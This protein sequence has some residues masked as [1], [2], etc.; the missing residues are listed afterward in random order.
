MTSRAA[1]AVRILVVEAGVSVSGPDETGSPDAPAA[2]NP[3]R[4]PR[5]SSFSADL[6]ALAAASASIRDPAAAGARGSCGAGISPMGAGGSMYSAGHSPPQMSA[7]N[8]P[9]R[10]A[11]AVPPQMKT[12]TTTS[13]PA[14]IA[15]P[16]IF[17]RRFT[18]VTIDED[19]SR[20]HTMGHRIGVEP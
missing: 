13:T 17:G 6:T 10:Y 20:V 1:N 7:F 16:L 9:S 18:Y 19:R 14:V 11:I 4:L 8:A 12:T 15:R 3:T 5:S 2:A